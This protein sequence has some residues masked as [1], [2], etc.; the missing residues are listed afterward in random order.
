MHD[1]MQLSMPWWTFALRGAL[2]YI[3]LLALL[4]FTGKRGLGDMSAFDIIV[5]VL[6]G[7]VLRTAILGDDHSL[8]A[9]VIGTLGILAMQKIIGWASARSARFNRLVEGWPTVLVRD[10]RRDRSKMRHHDISDSELDRALHE[11]GLEDEATIAVARLEPN[12]KIT[13]IRRGQELR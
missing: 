9:P 12:G 1:A 8:L 6:V 11:A 4:R 2:V 3:G 13:L 10:G 5:L 7:G